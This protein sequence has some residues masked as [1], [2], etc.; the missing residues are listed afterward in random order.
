MSLMAVAIAWGA[1]RFVKPRLAK[2]TLAE[3]RRSADSMAKKS[4]SPKNTVVETIRIGELSAERLTPPGGDKGRVLLW[5]HGGGY[6]A[7]SPPMERDLVTR[8]AGASGTSAL[9]PDYRLC[10]EHPLSASL[11]DALTAYR[12]QVRELGSSDQLVVGG[13]SAGGGLALRLLGA[14]RDAGDPLPAA[15]VVLSPLT[16]LALTGPSMKSNLDSDP[17]ISPG[18]I[19][20]TLE[21][22][23]GVPDRRDPSVSPLYA[24]MSGFPPLLIHVSGDELILD[25][26][27]R[28]AERARAAGAKV[29]LRVFPGLWHVFHG[30]ANLPESRKAVKEIG[31][32]VRE[33][34]ANPR[35]RAVTPV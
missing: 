34:L 10:P 5:F 35:S 16:D 20:M 4:K 31:E 32:F 8:I 30:M 7:G 1:R 18:F 23:S 25:D 13:S 26:S 24:D 21:N 2:S 28:V 12:W 14:L 22:L 11:E 29:T 33:H 27:V 9:V 17:M 6:V 15:A 3:L 19:R